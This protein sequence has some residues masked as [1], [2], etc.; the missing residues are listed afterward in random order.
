MFLTGDI[1]S[2]WAC[3]LPVDPGTYP[4]SR[5]VGVELVATSVTSNNLDDLT[6][7][8]PRT[9]SLA[10]EDAIRASNRH[11]KHLDFDSH[12]HSVLTI[13]PQE[14]Q[15]DWYVTSDR[16]DQAATS[17][18]STGW[19]VA[20]GS[21]T[22][23]RGDGRGPMTP[24]TGMPHGGATSRRTF[25]R[26][27]GALGGAVVLS[28]AAGAPLAAA[29]GARTRVYVLVTDGCRPDEVTADLTPNLHALRTAGTWYPNARS[30][31]V[32]ET[33][34][35]HV[36]MMTGV[37]PDRS[38]VP[39][40]AVFDR[41]E[42]AVRDLDRPSD[43]RFPTLLERLNA[44]GHRTGTV[45]SKSYLYGIFGTRATY[46]WEPSPLVPVTNH[47][48]DAFTT[49]A[50]ISMV[51][52]VDPD[53]VFTNLGDIDRVGHSDL[54]GSTTLEVAR[55]T[56]LASTDQQVGRFVQHLK[57]TGRW[58]SSVLVVLADHSMDWSVPT[59]VVSLAPVARRRPAAH[60]PRA[61]RA[62]RRR[63]PALLDRRRRRPHSGG[64][65]D[66]RGRR[67]SGR[68]AVDPPAVRPAAR[69]RGRRRGRLLQ[70]GLAVQRPGGVVEPHPR[71]P[72]APRHRA[73]P[74]LPR[75]RLAPGRVRRGAHRRW[76]TPSTSRRRSG[77]SSACPPPPAA[78]T[79]P[80]ASSRSAVVRLRWAGV[81]AERGRTGTR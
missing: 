50:L 64:D 43:L 68:R 35:N 27:A 11:V 53:L 48:P 56:A 49:D 36:M 15:M 37:R 58:E 76:R 42:G 19:K 13:T 81:S 52:S 39:A 22:A 77:S 1:H 4:L 29:A 20:V 70:G 55:K 5:T 75:G 24:T 66:A 16:T 46:R 67:G 63:R 60:R 18:W 6:G 32:M 47:A 74:V 9:A 21:N 33:I 78:T 71:Q 62:E 25:L 30:L 17:T 3:E 57:D 14:A 7:S 28:A 69:D 80:R 40:N 45:L 59:R 65:P 12:G 26:T 41:R 8:P 38:G 34:P 2:A 44:A 51:D 23:H 10:V 73:D 72:R 79:A 54:T 31:P 61:G